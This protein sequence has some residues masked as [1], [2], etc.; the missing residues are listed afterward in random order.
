LDYDLLKHQRTYYSENT[1]A[2]IMSSKKSIDID[3]LDDFE[4]AEYI[5][6]KGYVG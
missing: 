1:I 5:I 3:T 6:Q 2:Y 4:Y